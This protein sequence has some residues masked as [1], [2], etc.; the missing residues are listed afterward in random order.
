MSQNKTLLDSILAFFLQSDNKTDCKMHLNFLYLTLTNLIENPNNEEFRQFIFSP[1]QFKAHLLILQF[2]EINGFM[3]CQVDSELYLMYIEQSVEELKYLPEFIKS[4]YLSKV[5]EKEDKANFI[6]ELYE[7]RLTQKRNSAK[8]NETSIKKNDKEISFKASNI[9]YYK[10]K[11]IVE[12]DLKLYRSQMKQ[13]FLGSTQNQIQLPKNDIELPES[14][15]KE[16][17]N[18][19]NNKNVKKDN[20]HTFQSRKENEQR[21]IDAQIQLQEYREEMKREKEDESLKN[22][23]NIPNEKVDE[24]YDQ[25]IEIGLKENSSRKNNRKEITISELEKER[26]F[27]DQIKFGTIS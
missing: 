17:S 4:N 19:N 2:L 15:T 1:S 8:K 26:I 9:E 10:T 25:M 6:S 5:L 20:L 11:Q 12:E 24:N 7:S 16:I 23:S 14:K 22:K 27:E 3:Q 18:N 13:K 21:R